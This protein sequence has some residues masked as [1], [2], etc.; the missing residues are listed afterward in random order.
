[1]TIFE[2][3]FEFFKEQEGEPF[4]ALP[5]V[6]Q[7]LSIKLK[8]TDDAHGA[9]GEHYV[10]KCTLHDKTTAYSKENTVTIGKPYEATCLVNVQV[11]KEFRERRC[12]VIWL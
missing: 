8:D 2:S 4:R 7:V 5:R 9:A 11:F 3:M 1:M 6:L 10:V 12:K